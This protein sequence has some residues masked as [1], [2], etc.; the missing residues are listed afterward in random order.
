MQ[1]CIGIK[2]LHNEA[3]E[4]ISKHKSQTDSHHEKCSHLGPL[5]FG[6]PITKVKNN[7]WEESSFRNTQANAQAIK[8]P[9][10]PSEHTQRRNQTPTNHDA[11]DPQPCANSFHQQ[12][13]RH[14]K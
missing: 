9:L 4:W 13:T 10:I 2:V 1:A 14:L 7:A 11:C 8:A 12:I 5:A 3:G 6:E